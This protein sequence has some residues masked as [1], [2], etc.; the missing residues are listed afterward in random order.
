MDISKFMRGQAKTEVVD[1]YSQE[2]AAL[3]E[4][5][6]TGL[7]HF[8]V[9]GQALKTIRERK[10]YTP[11]YLTFADYIQARWGLSLAHVERLMTAADVVDNLASNGV[12]NLPAIESHARVLRRLAPDDQVK[13]WTLASS[14]IP[15]D[16]LTA[17]AIE[18]VANRIVPR[19]PKRS[20]NKS[21][22][23]ITL[24]GKGWSVTLTRR[25]STIDPVTVMETALAELRSKLKSKAAA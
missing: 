6:A 19:K 2:L 1:N 17:E 9:A 18:E 10:L 7:S 21:P 14:E 16:S 3:E 24:K 13:V 5:I 20:R 11:R 25:T 23:A 12:A 4:S 8:R 22:K 15:A